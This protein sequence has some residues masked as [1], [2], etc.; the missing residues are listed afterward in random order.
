ML[1]HPGTTMAHHIHNDPER[2][3]LYLPETVLLML[4]KQLPA[5]CPMSGTHFGLIG[6][7]R[8]F[9]ER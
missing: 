8:H 9:D 2:L 6:K 4:N 3:R 1:A 7:S 5:R